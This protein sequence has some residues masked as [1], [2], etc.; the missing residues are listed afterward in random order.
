MSVHLKNGRIVLEAVLPS[1]RWRI[2]Q[3]LIVFAAP[4]ETAMT[5][6]VGRP[7]RALLAHPFLWSDGLI[8]DATARNVNQTTIL[9]KRE[10][11]PISHA[12]LASAS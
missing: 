4:P 6:L 11:R 2:E 10:T 9:L 7:L 12:E 3:E 8:G 5:A 1:I